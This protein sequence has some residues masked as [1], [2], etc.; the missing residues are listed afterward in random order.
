MAQYSDRHRNSISR[1]LREDGWDAQALQAG[2]KKVEREKQ[3]VLLEM[4]RQAEAHE[5]FL[6]KRRHLMAR[7][8]EEYYKSL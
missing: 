2:L 8:I 7:M 1:F 3:L 4:L 5:N 6:S